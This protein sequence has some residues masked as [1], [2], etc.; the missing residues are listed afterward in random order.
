[1]TAKLRVL[2][3]GARAP[4]HS[5]AECRHVLRDSNGPASW[6]CAVYAGRYVSFVRAAVTCAGFEHHPPPRAPGRVRGWL[7]RVWRWIW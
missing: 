2:Q 4:V 1:M 3:G 6:R 7:V 5:C